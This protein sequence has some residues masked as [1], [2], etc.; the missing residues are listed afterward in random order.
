MAVEIKRLPV[1]ER[2]PWRSPERPHQRWSLDFVSDALWDHRRCRV[3][4]IVDPCTRECPGPSQWDREISETG[5][6]GIITAY[7]VRVTPVRSLDI[8]R[9]AQ[10]SAGQL[11]AVVIERVLR[12]FLDNR[13]W[14]P[15]H[16]DSERGAC[17]R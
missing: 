11:R 13:G 1:R 6:R 12:H 2:T 14:R 5:T 10:G 16:R 9:R 15:V 4:N 7:L 17:R 3:L 8:S